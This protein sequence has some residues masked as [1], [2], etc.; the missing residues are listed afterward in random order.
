MTRAVSLKP[1]AILEATFSATW[2]G[3]QETR[4]ELA[5]VLVPRGRGAGLRARRQRA[6][7]D[8]HPLRWLPATV[9]GSAV[10]TR[11]VKAVG[12]TVHGRSLR[13]GRPIS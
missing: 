13:W 1:S 10:G 12:S 7:P 8:A 11:A 2:L 4:G 9:V 3:L 5:G 6:G